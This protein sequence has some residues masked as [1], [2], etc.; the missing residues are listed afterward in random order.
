MSSLYRATSY[1]NHSN[2]L[3]AVSFSFLTCHSWIFE[4]LKVQNAKF[5]RESRI[6]KISLKIFLSRGICKSTFVCLTKH[7]ELRFIH[8]R[9]I[10]K[11]DINCLQNSTYSIPTPDYD[12]EFR[13][14]DFP[15]PSVLNST[16]VDWRRPWSPENLKKLSKIFQI[17]QNK[18]LNYMLASK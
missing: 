2:P 15:I 18:V 14:C 10:G 9:K 7:C 16:K 1:D 3:Q 5:L 6:F 13:A 8:H 12:S 11:P 17:L 4:F